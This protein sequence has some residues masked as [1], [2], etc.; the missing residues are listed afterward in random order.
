MRHRS[1]FIFAVTYFV[2]VF[3]FC[4]F[5]FFFSLLYDSGRQAISISSSISVVV[6]KKLIL[7]VVQL[8]MWGG[9]LISEYS[10]IGIMFLE[11]LQFWS[12]TAGRTG[13]D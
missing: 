12:V 6:F 9:A 11:T 7:A 3:S 13:T 8:H 5:F 10:Q 4:F 1:G 2:K